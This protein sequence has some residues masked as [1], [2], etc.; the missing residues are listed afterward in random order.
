MSVSASLIARRLTGVTAVAAAVVGAV[1]L[2]A[3]ATGHH[4]GDRDGDQVIISAVQYDAP[5]WDNRSI[6]SLN[7]EWVEIT[8]TSRHDVNL[9][10]WTLSN[11][12]GR[13][14]TFRH[15]RLD[16]RA[17]VRV[18]T[19]VGR[20]SA[21]DVYQDRRDHVW[22]NHDGTATL[23]TDRGRFVDEASWGDYR[24]HGNRHDRD[25]DRRYDESRRD[26][27]GRR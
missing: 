5:G 6:H 11:E 7:K 18:H 10:G 26:H 17:T 22:D 23:R 24:R 12:Y 13:T 20:D 14:Y 9:D 15:F 1:A 4:P 19:G 16:G 8:N 2:P 21:R 3:V 27:D 25:R